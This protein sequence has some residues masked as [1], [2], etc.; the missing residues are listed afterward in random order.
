MFL[1]MALDAL[2]ERI[3]M[4]QSCNASTADYVW[5]FLDGRVLPGRRLATLQLCE[6]GLTLESATKKVDRAIKD[7]RLQGKPFAFGAIVTT[8]ELP[9]LL[10]RC[11]GD[12]LAVATVSE[13][14]TTPVAPGW[15]RVALVAGSQIQ[16]QL[17]SIEAL[18]Q[19]G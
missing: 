14:L 2:P 16:L 19:R 5:I 17:V 1:D 3:A 18:R 6:S 9:A 15:F 8:D 11:G 10:R 7:G 4:L 13:W 12:E